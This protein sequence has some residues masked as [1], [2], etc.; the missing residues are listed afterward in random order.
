MVERRIQFGRS[1]TVF[2]KSE[3]RVAFRQQDSI[4]RGLFE[5]ESIFDTELPTASRQRIAN[6]N[7]LEMDAAPDDVEELSGRARVA[8]ATHDEKPVAVYHSSDDDVPFVPEGTLHLAFHDKVSQPEIDA[9]ADRH[10][11]HILGGA[12][13]GFY[14]ADVR[15]QDRDSIEIAEEI[16]GSDIVALAEP[17]LTTPV[18]FLMT[19]PSDALLAQQWHLRNS[20]LRD[21][22]ESFSMVKGADAR[23]IDAW[24]RLGHLGSSDVVLAMIDDGFDL[25]HPDL[26]GSFVH[27]RDFVRG[28]EDVRPEP[29][30]SEPAAGDWHG[31]PCAGV[32][33]A[34]AGGGK[35][36]GAAPN[37][38]LLPVR[39]ARH[40]SPVEVESWFDY[41]THKG[42]WVISCSWNAQAKVY[43]LPERIYQA[44][45]RAA[46]TGRDGKGAVIVFAAGNGS[47]DIN[48][49]PVS[50]NGYAT[51]P[52]VLAVAASTSVDTRAEYSDTGAEI[53]VC[54]PS[55]GRG[56]YGITTNDAT[57][58][59]VDNAGGSVSMGYNDGGYNAN[60]SGTSSACPLVAGVCALVL[61][62]NPALSAAEVR[63]LIRQTARQIGKPSEYNDGHS[64]SYGHGCVDA[65]AAV[66]RALA[67][68]DD[69]DLLLALQKTVRAR[70]E[71]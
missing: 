55:G 28:G 19:M 63:E 44:L 49:P 51:H 12:R 15:H 4:G 40:L 5:T 8:A 21:G 48:N 22:Q 33:V 39:M 38:R 3:S 41:V 68:A 54:A 70:A 47:S 62:A 26:A 30:Y 46:S 50:Q 6:F 35:T 32:A 60:F 16:Q 66:A 10:G 65:D 67:V 7:V 18:E 52:E 34:R 14:T 1:T 9:F 59:Y 31:T 37:A 43:P 27:P 58:H 45:S 23:V 17:D 64:T 29:N 61:S 13:D 36:V 20:G 24:E 71:V 56:G 2:T 53:A 11:L 25:A 57:G 69:H 42:A